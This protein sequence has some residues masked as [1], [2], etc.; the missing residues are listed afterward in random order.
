MEQALQNERNKQAAAAAEASRQRSISTL[1]Q[2]ASD[3]ERA[4][5]EHP[6]ADIAAALE[7]FDFAS[8]PVDLIIELIVANL[9][10]ISQ[11]TL[12][13]AV[14]VCNLIRDCIVAC[15]NDFGIDI[16]T[17]TW[18]WCWSTSRR[19]RH[20]LHLCNNFYCKRGTCGPPTDGY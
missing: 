2:E 1:T 6:S 9:R 10:S 15:W 13:G 7:N 5:T 20:R 11:D 19:F 14:Q 12:Q 16:P 18:N 4:Q 17:A 8:L 3:A